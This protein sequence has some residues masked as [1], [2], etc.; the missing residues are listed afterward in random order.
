MN[1]AARY[2][3]LILIVGAFLEASASAQKS[4]EQICAEANQTRDASP[5]PGLKPLPGR[6]DPSKLYY[7]KD[8]ETPAQDVWACVMSAEQDERLP[9]DAVRLMLF[10]NGRG[11]PKNLA[12]ATKLACNVKDV[13]EMEQKAVIKALQSKD[14]TN[15]KFDWCDHMITTPSVNVCV[16]I[17]ASLKLDRYQ[18]RISEFKPAD[19][20]LH[21]A[22]DELLRITTEY[23]DAR[24]MDEIDLSGSGRAV[25][26]MNE[27]DIQWRDFIDTLEKLATGKARTYSKKDLVQRSQRLQAELKRITASKSEWGTVTPQNII[28]TQKKWELWRS[29]LTKFAAQTWKT[30]PVALECWMTIKRVNML[31]NFKTF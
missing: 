23:I 24:S 30:D 26:V 2:T 31:K 9:T 1:Y 16:S 25:F 17:D 18:R 5:P 15:K 29:A 6:C 3:P 10:A 7:Q 13:P 20:K 12:M 22:W 8:P 27:T 19:P 4:V 11:A 21:A 14:A 28:A